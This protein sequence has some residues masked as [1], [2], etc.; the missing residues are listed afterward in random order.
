MHIAERVKLNS[1]T[2]ILNAEALATLNAIEIH[3]PTE[4]T[5]IFTDSLPVVKGVETNNKST[6][7][8]HAF[9]QKLKNNPNIKI[10]I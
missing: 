3:N 4:K 1:N 5:L 8:I 7:N 2:S 6:G 10:A 9:K